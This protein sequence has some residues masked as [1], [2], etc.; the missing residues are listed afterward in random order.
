[1]GP[2]VPFGIISQEFNYII[3][4]FIG[5]GFGY[6]LEQAGFSTSKKLVGVFYGYDYVVLRVFFTAAVTAVI[7]IILLDNIGLIDIDY[8]YINP[9]YLGPAIIGGGIMGLGFIIGGFCPGTSV[10]AASVGKIDA[11]V[12]IFGSFIG[13]FAFGELYPLFADFYKSG[14]QGSPFVYESLGISRGL[15]VFAL[16]MIAMIAFVVTDRLEN[17]VSYGSPPKHSKYYMGIPAIGLGI[18]F[19]FIMLF[20]PAGGDSIASNEIEINKI[21]QVRKVTIDAVAYDI[22]HELGK[23]QLID[24][25]DSAAYH[26]FCLPMAV[27]MNKNKI[28][29]FSNED[30]FKNPLKTPVFYSDD[31][32]Q[33][34]IAYNIA[35][36]N[37]YK[38]VA[39]MEEGLEKFKNK[40]YSNNYSISNAGFVGDNN[41]EFIYKVREYL[42]SDSKLT[43]P[44]VK[45]K[46]EK[47]ALKIEGGC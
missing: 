2:L 38:R 12:F 6:I 28:G 22:Y 13:I 47:K 14:F 9:L 10:V 36:K 8:L 1:M 27:R 37:G 40:Y 41:S 34:L 24:L 44:Q 26:S 23:Y 19:A 46:V 31:E 11:W 35:I 4:L 25:R 3:A 45:K 30:Y 15:F 16:S 42:N 18:I 21:D 20:M 29:D 32:E 39:I 17:R 43:K 33:V 5:F 7:G